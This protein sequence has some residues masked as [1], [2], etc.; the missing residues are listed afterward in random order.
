MYFLLLVPASFTRL[1][2]MRPTDKI[3]RQAEAN[4]AVT[5]ALN[6]RKCVAVAR[7]TPPPVFCRCITLYKPLETVLTKI[8]AGR[9]MK[10]HGRLEKLTLPRV[11]EQWS[12][13]WK[14]KYMACCIVSKTTPVMSLRRFAEIVANVFNMKK[15]QLKAGSRRHQSANVRQHWSMW[16]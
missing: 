13:Q 6:L 16:H 1:E 8:R 5:L 12:G 14:R 11:R 2:E 10:I 4:R 3:Q 15:N 9:W 7:S